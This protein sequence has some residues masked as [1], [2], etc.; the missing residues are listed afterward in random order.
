MKLRQAIERLTWQF[1]P[2]ENG[3]FRTF[4]ANETDRQS[5]NKILEHF[6]Q[7]QEKTIQ[8]NLLFAKLYA[9]ILGKLTCHYTD[10]DQATKHLNSILKQPLTTTTQMLEL[11]LRAMEM[12]QVFPEQLLHIPSKEVRAKMEQ[13][14]DLTANVLHAIDM[15]DS[16]N[17]T[18]YLNTNINLSIQNFKNY[19]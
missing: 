1:T 9:Y 17:V 2:D 10:A 7:S 14:P 3:K 11:E 8:E 19:V 18:S 4:T 5:M 13:Y 15:W 6:K 16:D 12:R